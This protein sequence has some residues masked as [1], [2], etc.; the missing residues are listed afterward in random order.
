MNKIL[1]SRSVNEPDN[2]KLPIPISEMAFLLAYLY[3]IF[4]LKEHCRQNFEQTE[5]HLKEN[6]KEEKVKLVLDFFRSNGLKC[7][8]DILHKFDLREYINGSM[9]FHD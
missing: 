1:N 2:K 3:E 8:C 5:W 7:D 6:H 4:T 9:E